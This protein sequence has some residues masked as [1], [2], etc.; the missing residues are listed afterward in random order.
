MI[1]EMKYQAEKSQ[2]DILETI[3]AGERGNQVTDVNC[4][5][6][7]NMIN[8]NANADAINKIA[9]H[10]DV[11]AIIY[12]KLEKLIPDSGLVKIENCTH[13]VFLE[14]TDYV[15]KII[16]TFLTGGN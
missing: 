6:L 5:W 8:C 1:N 16:C 10:P 15:N 13:Y 12:N 3:Q 4:H 14:R 2:A 7:T 9:K 11:E